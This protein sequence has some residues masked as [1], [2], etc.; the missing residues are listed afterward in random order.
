MALLSR[1][2]LLGVLV[3]VTAACAQSGGAVE[4]DAGNGGDALAPDA[5]TDGAATDG[6]PKT[7]ASG[8]YAIEVK[9]TGLASDTGD[10][11]LLSP[12]ALTA[13]ARHT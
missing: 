13:Y 7:D 11:G 2:R 12:L 1:S 9:V 10:A 6:G 5:A 4:E 3:L 8:L